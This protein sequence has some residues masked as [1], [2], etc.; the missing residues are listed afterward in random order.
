MTLRRIPRLE[1]VLIV[2]RGTPKPPDRRPATPSAP[3]QAPD[4]PIKRGNHPGP[5]NPTPVK[6]GPVQVIVPPKKN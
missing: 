3:K 4:T 2:D 1:E 5:S 6:P